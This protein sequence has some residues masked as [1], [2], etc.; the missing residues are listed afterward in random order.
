MGGAARGYPLGLL[1]VGE[2]LNYSL[3]TVERGARVGV[4]VPTAVKLLLDA[5]GADYEVQR[6]SHP[7]AHLIENDLYRVPLQRVL[8]GV[9]L[10]PN[11]PKGEHV[12]LVGER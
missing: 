9:Q 8:P 1:Q 7:A 4:L 10:V 6:L 5:A 11:G 2:L 3:Q 12:T